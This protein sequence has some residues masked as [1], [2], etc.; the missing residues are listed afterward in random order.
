M[1]TFFARLARLNR[2]TRTLLAVA[3][4]V[5]SVAVAVGALLALNPVLHVWRLPGCGGRLGRG[6]GQHARPRVQGFR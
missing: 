1:K 2:R 5:L 4:V 6:R 3:G